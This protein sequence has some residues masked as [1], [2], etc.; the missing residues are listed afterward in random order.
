MAAGLVPIDTDVGETS[1]LVSNGINGLL[2]PPS[3][4]TA[5]SNAIITLIEN[6]KLRK[7]LSSDA[8]LSSKNFDVAKGI[9]PLLRI[10]REVSGK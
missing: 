10:Y 7:K 8:Q 5:L 2:I 6:E 1:K 9:Q 3:D 4:P